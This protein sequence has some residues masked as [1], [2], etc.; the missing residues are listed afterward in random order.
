MSTKTHKKGTA[1]TA[2]ETTNEATYDLASNSDWLPDTNNVTVV[3]DASN[4]GLIAYTVTFKATEAQ[5]NKLAALGALHLAQRGPASRVE[6]ILAGYDKSRKEMGDGWTRKDIGYSAEIADKFVSNMQREI[7][8]DCADPDNAPL[9]GVE[10]SVQASEYTPSA[11][12]IAYAEAQKIVKNAIATKRIAN[13][14]KNCGYKG[15]NHTVENVEF[16]QAVEAYRQ[17]LISERMFA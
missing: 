4:F 13:L 3:S 7:A 8:K 15:G 12:E 2:V 10:V 11:R 1:I 9:L 14:V 17:Q 6:K 5:V 16:L